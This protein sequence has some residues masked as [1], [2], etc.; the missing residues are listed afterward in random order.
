M[1]R[2]EFTALMLIKQQRQEKARR[3]VAIARQ[4]H[5]DASAKRKATASDLNTRQQQHHKRSRELRQA[6]MGRTVKPIELELGRLELDRL[7]AS[8]EALRMLL[9]TVQQDEQHEALLLSEAHAVWQRC[10]RE[11]DRWQHVTR[12]LDKVARRSAERREEDDTEE[13]G[14][15]A[16]VSAAKVVTQRA[17]PQDVKR[18]IS[19]IRSFFGMGPHDADG[20]QP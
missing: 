2:A 4:R 10:V 5:A 6:I 16:A 3:T 19:D 18:A 9:L 17:G 11:V 12:T 1:N 20:G 13:Q 15:T 14:T 8:V 7:Q